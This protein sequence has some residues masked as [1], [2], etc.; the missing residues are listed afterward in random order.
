MKKR[1]ACLALAASLY[2]GAPA[3]GAN[4]V[5]WVGDAAGRLATIDVV[6]G[7]TTV[8]GAMGYT[9]YDIA[10]DPTGH[11]YGINGS[12]LYSIDPVTAAASFI[13]TGG[14]GNINSLVFGS[15]GKLYGASTALYVFDTASGA[16]TSIGSLGPGISSSGD[17]AFIDGQLYLTGVA[18]QD[19]LY[20]VSTSTGAATLVGSTGYSEVY[21]LARPNGHDLYG[22][23]GGKVLRVD[24]STGAGTLLSTANGAPLSSVYGAAFYTESAPPPIPEPSSWALML[25][26]L[27]ALGL[28]GRRRRG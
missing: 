25:A 4:P 5:L 16:R 24:V 3:A 9:M 22:F 11:L 12:S 17:L 21:G 7:A 8:I 14:G 1:L 15:D 2:A 26:G 19:R 27:A 20:R 28:I 13:G 18:S 23:S 6:T 10:F